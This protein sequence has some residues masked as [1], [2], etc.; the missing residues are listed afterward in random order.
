MP[1]SRTDELRELIPPHSRA[2][3]GESACCPIEL[4]Q[5]LEAAQPDR[6]LLAFT[7]PLGG[8][9]AAA[10]G[11]LRAAREH[12]AALLLRVDLG[13]SQAA[14]SSAAFSA[15][16]KACEES[17]YVWPIGLLAQVPASPS[18]VGSGATARSV[19]D[20][21]GAGFPSVF[22]GLPIAAEA[23]VLGNEL[24]GALAAL[25]ERELG[26]ALGLTVG[27]DSRE[28]QAWLSMLAER[29]SLPVAVR[30]A[31]RDGLP[32]KLRHWRP[33]RG[34][35]QPDQRERI[36][37]SSPSLVDVALAMPHG[38][39]ADRAEAFAYFAAETAFAA[40]DQEK[41]ALHVADHLRARWKG[42]P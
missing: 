20:A 18:T 24:L 41:S 2:Q 26:W 3:V 39:R 8:L 38:A 9:G 10:A 13:T 42:S 37:S 36:R 27:S 12:S 33:T 25:K 6:P 29:D 35:E 16:V 15:L 31:S 4:S 34:N 14:V 21:L 22:L 23:E 5:L 32:A 11:V 19:A 30:C 7:P 17:R 28:G 40:W 1:Q